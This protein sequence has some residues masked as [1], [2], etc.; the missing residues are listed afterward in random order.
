MEAASHLLFSLFQLLK[1]LF[2][3]VLTASCIPLSLYLLDVSYSLPPA[4]L[5]LFH[6]N[7]SSQTFFPSVFLLPYYHDFAQKDPGP[8]M[9]ESAFYL[10]ESGRGENVDIEMVIFIF[11]CAHIFVKE[12]GISEC[13]LL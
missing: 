1:I 8:R 5:C 4:I 7:K 13:N 12:S 6:A 10:W 2:Q 11:L 3:P 9:T